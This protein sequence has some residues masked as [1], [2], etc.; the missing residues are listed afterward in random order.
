VAAT[1]PPATYFHDGPGQ[2]YAEQRYYGTGTGRFWSVDVMAGYL[3]SP[4]SLNRYAYVRGDP[5]NR[6]D[7]NGL[8]DVLL[9][10][11]TMNPGQNGAFD[12]LGANMITAFPYS[13]TTP[14][15][16]VLRV[17]GQIGGGNS[18]TQL[19]YQA[20][21]GAAAQSTGPINVFTFSG[22]AQA[23]AAALLLLP[24]DVAGRI[25]NITYISPGSGG[26]NLPGTVSGLAANG[27]TTTVLTGTK[28]IWNTLFNNTIGGNLPYGA[29]WRRTELCGHDANC[30]VNQYKKELQ[31]IQG[32]PCSNPQTLTLANLTANLGGGGGGGNEES[33]GDGGGDGFN[34]E[35]YLDYFWLL[36]SGN[37]IAPAK[38]ED[39]TIIS[40]YTVL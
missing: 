22:G 28:G 29:A 10:G 7:Q 24:S 17:A 3:D 26:G 8:C 18:A 33:G 19:A 15:S 20:I 25:N 1:S 23:F 38:K 11:I 9:A 35:A 13:G 39:V 30:M 16:G 6:N 2:D 31:S 32:S 4:Q 36:Y 40:T 37:P 21:M 12:A 14:I 27:G 34:L 5:V